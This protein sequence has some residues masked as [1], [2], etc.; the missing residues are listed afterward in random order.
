ML[1][2]RC[3]SGPQ[4]AQHGP[5][6]GSL[7]TEG[8]CS[9]F[10]R[11]ARPSHGR[12]PCYHQVWLRLPGGRSSDFRLNKV[13]PWAR[14]SRPHPGQRPSHRLGLSA[15]DAP[16]ARSPLSNPPLPPPPGSG[17]WSRAV[18]PFPPPLLTSGLQTLWDW[19][20]LSASS[21]SLSD[22]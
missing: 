21:F 3:L 9:G 6:G 11:Q 13:F 14:R 4:T 8:G 7:L 18:V 15:A 12:A 22:W 16:R 10:F 17:G 19:L 20:R 2:G 1:L 5:G